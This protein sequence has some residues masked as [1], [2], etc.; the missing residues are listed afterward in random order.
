MTWDGWHP[1]W[2]CGDPDIDAMHAR[3]LEQS[4][5]LASAAEADNGVLFAD[6]LVRLHDLTYDHFV[7][8]ERLIIAAVG[9]AH[10]RVHVEDH[11]HLLKILSDSRGR[12]GR[13][14][15]GVDHAGKRALGSLLRRWLIKEISE[16]DLH[17]LRLTE[18]RA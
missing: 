2:S 13:E 17:F 12:L 10:A 18:V 6:A 11:G 5:A 8:E 4:F 14:G 1:R 7:A 16:H 9:A 15:K 3:I